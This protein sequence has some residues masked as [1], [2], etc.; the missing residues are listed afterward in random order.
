MH[1][2]VSR[3]LIRLHCR[4]KLQLSLW[5]LGLHWTHTDYFLSLIPK[6][7]NI[8]TLHRLCLG[9]SNPE[10]RGHT[11]ALCPYSKCYSVLDRCS[12]ICRFGGGGLL[13][14]N[15]IDT[16]TN[17]TALCTW[18]FLKNIPD[19]CLLCW[20]NLLVV[21]RDCPC[22]YLHWQLAVLLQS[23][24]RFHFAFKFL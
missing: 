10:M 4:P 12:G 11:G 13:W 22:L 3:V 14:L 23:F 16:R 21:K 19:Q 15:P 8:T 2:P 18:E 17:N 5:W 9:M 6:R 24:Q 20:I 7:Y 1:L